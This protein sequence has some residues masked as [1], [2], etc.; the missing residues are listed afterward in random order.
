MSD[1]IKPARRTTGARPAAAL[2]FAAFALALSAAPARAQDRELLN[3]LF[4]S[5]ST[6]DAAMRVFEQGRDLLNE[7]KFDQA[8]RA[9]DR[10]LKEYP[11]HENA[12]A[13]LYWLAYSYDKQSLF[14]Q[15]EGALTLL[16]QKYPKTR[17][18]KDAKLLDYKVKS[19]LGKRVSVPDD[20]DCQNAEL[21]IIALQSLCQTDK[22]RCSALIGDVLKSSAPCSP[23]VKR[24]AIALLAR[25]GGPEAVPPLMQMAR[26]EPD[27]ALRRYAI[28]GLG[29]TGDER[30]LDLLRELA[31]STEYDDESPTD[32]AIHA[33]ANHESPRAV[34]ILGDVI[35]NGRNLKA[36]Q[37]AVTLLAGRRGE[38]V[39]DELLRLYDAVPDLSVRQYVVAGLG[40]RR[41]PRVVNRLVEIARTAPQPEL[42][43]QAIHAIPNRNED[44]DLD[45]LLS[46]YDSERDEELKTY[47]LGAFGRYDNQ[48]AYQKLMQ[49]VRSNSEPLERRKHAIS[50]L[51]RSKDPAVLKF[52]EDMLK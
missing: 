34:G 11:A 6:T 13:G 29:T 1:A 50:L 21:K 40:R 18:L 28:Q 36:R 37:H 47:I 35:A 2:L 38:N 8:A 17:W 44:Q 32:S 45:V 23:P 27:E 46:L 16:M 42:R 39:A 12:D 4:Q 22:A 52:L 10:F 25:Y 31:M 7:G 19:K 30:G 41:E 14:S 49:V 24:A 5:T 43:K 15:A 9:F 51:S 33:L 3:R 20:P 26:S 48:R